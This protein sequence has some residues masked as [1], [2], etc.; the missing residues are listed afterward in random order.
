MRKSH[1]SITAIFRHS[2]FLNTIMQ[3]YLTYHYRGIFR[4]IRLTG[5]NQS[6]L[7]SIFDFLN[8]FDKLSYTYLVLCHRLLEGRNW[9]FDGCVVRYV[10]A[11]T[12]PAEVRPEKNPLY[13]AYRP[14]QVRCPIGILETAVAALRTPARR[15]N[16]TRWC[17][18]SSSRILDA[19]GE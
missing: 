19:R 2:L 14:G 3:M 8:R 6:V 15:P 13:T 7:Q 17:S 16:E 4:T 1:F 18:V 11:S 10:V 5:F 9:Y 12:G